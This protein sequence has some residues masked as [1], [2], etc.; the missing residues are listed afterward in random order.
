MKND[1]LDLTRTLRNYMLDIDS[2]DKDTLYAL[3]D[4]QQQLINIV[5]NDLLTYGAELRTLLCKIHDD[6]LERIINFPIDY[7]NV[8]HKDIYTPAT[9]DQY[10]HWSNLHLLKDTGL[11][12]YFLAKEIKSTP[13]MLL[14]SKN[15]E[16]TYIDLL[17]E[18]ILIYS[19]EMIN[20]GELGAVYTRNNGDQLTECLL[21]LKQNTSQADNFYIF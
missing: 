13:Y 2:L 9:Q 6:L 17:P 8:L 19:D 4:I 14:C 18:L 15:I 3:Y 7:S 5:N 12:G 16:Y 10:G 11:F 20:Y 1:V 21:N